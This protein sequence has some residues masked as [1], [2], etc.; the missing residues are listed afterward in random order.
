MLVVQILLALAAVAAL[1]RRPGSRAAVAVA[2]GCAA[3]ELLVGAASPALAGTAI[4]AALPLVPFLTAAIWLS[5]HAERTGLADRLAATATRLAHRSRPALYG[6]VCGLCALLTATVS[7]DGAVVLMVPV[8]LALARRAPELRRP[9]LFGTVAVANAFSLALPQGNPANVV[10]MERSGLGP[11]DFV[12]HLMLPALAATAVCAGAVALAERRALSGPFEAT[13]ARL[14][15]WSVDERIAAAGLV[16]AGAAGALA[17][18]VGIAPWWP[19]CAVASVLV[20]VSWIRERTL[21][22]VAV[23]ARVC[24]LVA[25]LTVVAGAVAAP[26]VATGWAPTSL[27]ALVAVAL[28]ASALSGA[29]NNLPASAVL[30]TLLANPAV[31]GAALAGLSAGS[32]ATPHGSVATVLALERA[33]AA[34]ETAGFAGYL[35]LWLPTAA[36]A[37]AIAAAA[38]WAL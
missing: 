11:A 31:A 32:L 35:R 4:H 8:V 5:A 13:A 18:W 28:A 12:A 24:L 7:L 27:V 19:L 14:P 3:L 2:A 6:L 37:A 10:V 17:P 36:G 30:S 9:L 25:S 29:V 16:V 34:S 20:A 33:G 26:L 22:R 38:I 23:P 21:P 1:V 15:S